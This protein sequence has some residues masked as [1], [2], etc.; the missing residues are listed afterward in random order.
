MPALLTAA[1]LLA[2]VASTLV[3]PP[4]TG[5]STVAV[6]I[7]SFAFNPGS[8]TVVIGVNNTVT[9]TNQ[10]S[11]THTVTANDGSFDHTLAPGSSFSFTFATAGTFG[12]H[13]SI[14]TYMTGTVNV[15]GTTPSSTT[16]ST[17]T[18]S[19]MTSGS[20]TSST[21]SRTSLTSTPST[22]S[23]SSTSTSSA[24][25]TASATSTLSDYPSPYPSS[26]TSSGTTASAAG[27]IP[28]FPYQAAVVAVVT[29]LVVGAYL[30]VR[31]S[32]RTRRE[33]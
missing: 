19:V 32:S 27:G 33:H 4:A 21:T 24:S 20:S 11:V 22:T 10:D 3:A 7:Q 14:H 5:A 28:E 17:S 15:A 6:N 18:S 26:Y 2:L 9:W 13:C 16:S 1:L 31:H 29:L 25:L 8:I 30:G 12:Y 23:I